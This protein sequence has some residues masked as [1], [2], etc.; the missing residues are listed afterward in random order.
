MSWRDLLAAAPEVRVLPWTGGHALADR[1]RAWTIEG[2]LPEEHGWHAFELLGAR[3]ARWRAAEM[4]DGTWEEGRETVRGYLVGDRIVPDDAAVEP[5]PE[6]LVAQTVPVHLVEPGQERFARAVAAR[7]EG[8]P[9][10]WLR[11][12]F[13]LG[14]ELE[15][16]TAFEDRAP[17]LAGIRGVTPALLLAY[18]FAVDQRDHAEARR[19]AARRRREAEEARRRV[20]ERLGDGRDRRR[21]ASVDFRAAAEAALGLA[22]AEL[23]DE[24]DAPISGE[25]IVRWR[26][27]GRRFESVVERETL[28]IIDAG[29][30]LQDHETGERGDG[31][32]T[33]ESLPGVIEEAV[34]DGVLVVFRHVEGR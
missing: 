34:R 17:D 30:C 18:R 11:P 33:L 1:G 26:L 19:E 29:I 25:K 32:F 28:R 15:V 8:G 14:P 31:S 16:T 24:R 27:R 21:L 3:R 23:L 12:E 22:G 20:E 5:D 7:D 10:I 6:R 9:W 4:P 13:P 2:D